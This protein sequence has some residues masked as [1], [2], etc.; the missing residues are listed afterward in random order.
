MVGVKDMHEMDFKSISK[1]FDKVIELYKNNELQIASGLKQDPSMWGRDYNTSESQITVVFMKMLS[2]LRNIQNSIKCNLEF[3]YALE[4]RLAGFKFDYLNIVFDRSTIQDDLKFQQAEEIKIRN[5]TAKY[6]MGTIDEAAVANELG[7]E[8]YKSL[9]RVDLEII[10]GGSA[11][12]DGE[13]QATRQDQKNKSAKKT[14]DKNKP[15]GSKK[16]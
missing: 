14:R 10:A 1:D 7:Y 13:Q 8:T 3:G 2:Q 6:I 15:Q 5:V 16:Q 11:P 12:K 4:L 9:P